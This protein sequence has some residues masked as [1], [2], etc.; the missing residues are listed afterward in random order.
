MLLWLARYPSYLYSSTFCQFR[1]ELCP[2]NWCGLLDTWLR[3]C[4]LFICYQ[5]RTHTHIQQYE[6]MLASHALP[7][8]PL[9]DYL[10]WEGLLRQWVPP[11]WPQTLHADLWNIIWLV[12]VCFYSLFACWICKRLKRFSNSESWQDWLTEKQ[13]VIISA[14]SLDVFSP[15]EQKWQLTRSWTWILFPVKNCRVCL[16]LFIA[17]AIKAPRQWD[18]PEII[19]DV[20]KPHAP[21]AFLFNSLWQAVVLECLVYSPTDAGFLRLKYNNNINRHH[22]FNHPDMD[23]LDSGT[24]YSWKNKP[25]SAL[26]W[27]NY[28]KVTLFLNYLKPEYNFLLLICRHIHQYH[29]ALIWI[30]PLLGGV[31][32]YVSYFAYMGKFKKLKETFGAAAAMLEH[33]I[34]V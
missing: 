23:P 26:W 31:W 30:L 2:E 29:Q 10:L 18:N 8:W 13:V 19:W 24:F 17:A 12:H 7:W 16:T 20:R 14:A 15:H 1:F 32:T 11:S 27:T 25:V 34:I 4:C 28:V 22:Y 5:T 21:L 33:L 9:S 6:P 3:V